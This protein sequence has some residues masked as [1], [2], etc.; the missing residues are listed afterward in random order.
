MKATRLLQ[1][2]A[3]AVTP[4]SPAVGAD[5]IAY[6]GTYT[7]QDSKGIYAYR[8]EAT[9]GKLTALGMAAAEKLPTPPSW[10]S[11]PTNASFM[12]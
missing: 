5:W 12:P 2:F 6:I 4:L 9:T 7:R 10:Q 11:P 1:L 3:A 8:F